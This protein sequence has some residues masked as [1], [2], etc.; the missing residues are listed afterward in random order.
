MGIDINDIE[1]VVHFAPTGNVCDYV[2]EIG[3]AARR[4]DL[5]GEAYYHYNPKDF[6]HINRLHGLSTIQHYQLIKVIEK[7]NE[8]YQQSLHSGK[9]ADM[10]K[11]RNAM[12]LDAENFSYIF[13]PAISDEDDNINK[14]KTALLLIQKDFESKIGFSPIN[15]RPI[16]M[17]SMGFFEI[18]PRVQEKLKK[19]YPECVEE[20]EEQKHICRVRLS[21]IW[22]K[23]YKTHS[24]PKF[25]FMVYSKSEDIDFITK[26]P[27]SPALCV[28]I[29][30]ENDYSSIFRNTWDAIKKFIFIKVQ[31]GEHTAVTDIAE[32]IERE[33][34]VNKYKAR[35]ICEVVIAS[36]DAYRKNFAKTS[37]PIAIEKTTIDG[38][39]KYQFNVAVNSYFAWVEKGLKKVETDTKNGMLYLINDNGNRTKEYSII[40]GILEAMGCLTF[41][42][43]GGANSQLYIYINQIQAL[44]NIIKAPYRYHNRLLEMVAERHL[45]SVKMLT[46]IYEGDF[47]N[48]ETWDLIEDYFLGGIPEKVKRDCKKEKPDMLFDD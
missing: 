48:D 19:R 26:Y 6:K 47:S 7:I 10:T 32:E 23:D 2:Q 41:E 13:G 34:G 9:K 33:C 44:I 18:D 17:F 30:F 40:L 43:L 35:T 22:N 28:N 5:K 20:I 39:T 27:M 46:Y 42:M 1:L 16:P 11:K 38:N 45:I 24:F 12:L 37:T 31:S 3:R 15:V 25:K 21:A 29:G 36:M 4:E 14:V 8:L